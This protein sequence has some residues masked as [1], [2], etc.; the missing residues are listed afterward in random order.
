MM[1]KSTRPFYGEGRRYGRRERSAAHDSAG[2]VAMACMKEEN[3]RNT[4]SPMAW[5]G[6]RP[7]GSP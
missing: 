3:R 7:T 1:R 6:A 4:G 2:V 5:S